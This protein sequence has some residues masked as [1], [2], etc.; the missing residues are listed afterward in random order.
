MRHLVHE[1]F[2]ET[3]VPAAPRG[4]VPSREGDL[5]GHAATAPRGGHPGG[6]FGGPT[7]G[8]QSG[9][10]PRL[11]GGRRGLDRL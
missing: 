7:C 1:G 9:R 3:Q 4:G 8:V 2:G 10:R 6:G 5:A 11:A